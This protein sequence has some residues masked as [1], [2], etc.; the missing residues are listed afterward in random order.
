MSRPYTKG[1]NKVFEVNEETSEI[2]GNQR[3]ENSHNHEILPMPLDWHPVE[4]WMISKIGR[5]VRR[6][7]PLRIADGRVYCVTLWDS[8][9]AILSGITHRRNSVI[10]QFCSKVYIPPPIPH[11]VGKEGTEEDVAEPSS[12]DWNSKR[13]RKPI[14]FYLKRR[15]RGWRQ[16]FPACPHIPHP[17]HDGDS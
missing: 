4:S 7:Q 6:E 9:L 11:L 1:G 8:D 15:R 3:N 12:E 5:E 13:R 17:A 16:V 2:V 10:Q 14:V